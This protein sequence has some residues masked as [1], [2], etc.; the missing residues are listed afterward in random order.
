MLEFWA[1][2]YPKV[3][4]VKKKVENIGSQGQAPNEYSWLTAGRYAIII[5][6]LMPNDFKVIVLTIYCSSSSSSIFIIFNSLN[7]EALYWHS[8]IIN[9]CFTA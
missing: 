6:C 4:S 1:V 2:T 8:E 9:H 3:F 7:V 5:V